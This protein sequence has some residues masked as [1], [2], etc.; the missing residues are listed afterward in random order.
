MF[1]GEL[2]QGRDQRMLVEQRGVV[3]GLFRGEHVSIRIAKRAADVTAQR[4]MRA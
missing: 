4:T 3:S 1:A 2:S